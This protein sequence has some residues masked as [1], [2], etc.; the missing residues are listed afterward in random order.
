MQVEDVIQVEDTPERRA[1]RDRT[2]S[3]AADGVRVVKIYWE[4]QLI[5]ASGYWL[6]TSSAVSELLQ[7]QA[8]GLRGFFLRPDGALSKIGPIRQHRLQ[9]ATWR[10]VHVA[11]GLHLLNKCGR[12]K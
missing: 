3:G 5:L 7:K 1:T 2:A 4:R 8:S 9:L 10:V 6:V 12:A 11:M